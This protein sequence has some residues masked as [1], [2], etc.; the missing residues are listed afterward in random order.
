MINLINE[1]MSYKCVRPMTNRSGTLLTAIKGYHTTVQFSFALQ[2]FMYSRANPKCF[3]P[4]KPL[5]R[6]TFQLFQFI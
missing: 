1:N 3:N 2:L 6:Q 5:E 4:S